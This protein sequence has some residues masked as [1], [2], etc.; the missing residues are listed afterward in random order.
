M[1]KALTVG[2][3]AVSGSLHHPTIFHTAEVGQNYL[4][5]SRPMGL[6]FSGF[7]VVVEGHGAQAGPRDT[8]RLQ[9]GQRRRLDAKIPTAQVSHSG[10]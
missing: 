3:H 10:T 5:F 9:N 6:S 4:D 1:L 7:W 8:V 2:P